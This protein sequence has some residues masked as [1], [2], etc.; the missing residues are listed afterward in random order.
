VKILMVLTSHDTLGSTGRKTGF[1]LEELAAPYYV[2]KEAGVEVVLASPKG[3][4]P[5]L[6]PKSNETMFQTEQTRRFE[7]DAE[8]TAQLANTVRLDSVS[9]VDFDSVFYPGGHGPLWDLAED[10]NSIALIESFIGAGK[11]IALVCHAPGVLRD[12]K[13]LNGRPLVEGKKVTGFAN[14]EEEGVGLTKV[15]PFLVEDM[16]IAKGGV[17]SKGTD[18][19]SYVVADGLLITGQN[20]ASSADV[21]HRLLADIGG[22]G[23]AY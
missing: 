14:T 8:A 12:V 16:L 6:D 4:H 3:G 13:A 11:S 7:E 2:F 21:A 10:K 18:W 20:P 22:L 15:V 23:R 9:Q 17:Y 19:G 5:P 1:W